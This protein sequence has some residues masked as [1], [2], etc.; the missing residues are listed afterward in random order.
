M[1]TIVL[2][3]NLSTDFEEGESAGRA[4]R[5]IQAAVD[6]AAG[7]GGGTIHLGEGVFRLDSAIHLRSNIKLVG[8]PGKT[9][10]FKTNERV[11]SLLADADLHERQVTVDKPEL[12]PVGQ[13]VT[14]R[15]AD[16]SLGF[17]DTV[18]IV[19]AKEGQT[20]FLDRELNASIAA[21]GGIVTT[22]TPV[23][24]GYDCEQAEIRNL[25]VDG[26]KAQHSRADGCRNGGIF[27]FRS[28]RVRIEGCTVRDYN[29]DGISYQICSDIDV[30]DCDVVR[31]GGKGIHPGSG[32]VRTHIRN[33]RFME[34]GM[35]GIF[36]CWRVQDSLV[37]HNVAAGNGMSGL[38]IGHKD[39]R[40]EIRYNRFS[41]NRF[42]GIFFRNETESS[43]ARSNRIEG[44]WIEDNGSESMGYV[45]IRIRGY[46]RDTDLVANR[47]SFSKAPLDR[48]IGI[49]L[50]EHTRDIRVQ[51]NEFVNC[52]MNTHTHWLPI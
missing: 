30:R 22:Q 8:V 27:L 17:G 7:L 20:L 38:S 10:L 15:N 39:N 44:N 43:S 28:H 3:V 33:S 51:D 6:Y 16:S 13:T 40:N 50:E 11:A 41:D 35:D 29:G 21:D 5:A 45:G 36:L 9:V 47:I 18:A 14:I 52:R 12:F 31:N 48:T 32:T 19:A 34:N 42:Y 4:N 24:S 49:C 37:E 1:E 46:T 2:N 25:I 26:N 23:I